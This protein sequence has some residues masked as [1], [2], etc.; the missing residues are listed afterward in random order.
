MQPLSVATAAAPAE[1][2][3]HDALDVT[4]AKLDACG[5]VV[6]LYAA[7][8]VLAATPVSGAELSSDA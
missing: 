6:T 1:V 5:R 2:V 7:S 8:A 4:D 3:A